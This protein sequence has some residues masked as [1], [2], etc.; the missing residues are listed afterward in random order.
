MDKRDVVDQIK[1]EMRAGSG[2]RPRTEIYIQRCSNC[3]ATGYNSHTCP[4]VIETLE[5][6]NSE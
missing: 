1:Q 2:R 6:D 3:N 5:E 4:I